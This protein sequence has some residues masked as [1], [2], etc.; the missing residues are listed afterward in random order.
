MPKLPASSSRDMKRTIITVLKEL[1]EY[2][3]AISEKTEKEVEFK[4]I[5]LL[6][7]LRNFSQTKLTNQDR[8]EIQKIYFGIDWRVSS[9]I[10]EKFPKLDKKLKEMVLH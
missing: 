10:R 1:H 9:K 5:L 6:S 2:I 7:R 3:S 4:E 8:V